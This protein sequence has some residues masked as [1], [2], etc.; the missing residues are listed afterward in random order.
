MD[1]LVFL[2]LKENWCLSFMMLTL[3]CV[4]IICLSTVKEVYITQE[5]DTKTRRESILMEETKIREEPR[6]REEPRA[7]EE[8]RSREEPR[9]RED[10]LKCELLDYF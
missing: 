10:F 1:K 8:S 2:H 9:T 5:V 7:R 6:S 3:P 4:F